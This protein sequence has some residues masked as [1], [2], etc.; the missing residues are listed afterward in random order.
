M[1]LLLEQVLA[2]VVEAAERMRVEQAEPEATVAG[3]SRSLQWISR[4]AQTSTRKE[5]TVQ[6][7]ALRQRVAEAAVLAAV[8]AG[9]SRLLQ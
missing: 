2:A 9:R 1:R 3:L 5:T 7:A 6:M 8:P 4:L